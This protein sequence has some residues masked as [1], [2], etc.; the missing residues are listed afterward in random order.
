ME[1]IY[2]ELGF[3]PMRGKNSLYI[4][5]NILHSALLSPHF[6]TFKSHLISRATHLSDF[7]LAHQHF[8]LRISPN[9][10]AI[11]ITLGGCLSHINNETITQS[12]CNK[13]DENERKTR[14]LRNVAKR[15]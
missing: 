3:E 15:N 5:T 14:P 4:C 7:M 11:I 1:E 12:I 8:S 2:F 9:H 6:I 10:I 13:N